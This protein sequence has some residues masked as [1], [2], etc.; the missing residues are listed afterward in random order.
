MELLQRLIEIDHDYLN[1]STDKKI[2]IISRYDESGNW[3]AFICKR[4]NRK[5]LCGGHMGLGNSMFDLLEWIDE[6]HTR[7]IEVVVDKDWFLKS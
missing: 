7:R 4:V 6:M 1:T 5:I 2:I 3:A